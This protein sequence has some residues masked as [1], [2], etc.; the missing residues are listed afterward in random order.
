MRLPEL[1][2]CRGQSGR[3]TFGLTLI[4][5]CLV[6]H[7]LF[8][9]AS[10][11][12]A[13]SRYRS[14]FNYL[15]SLWAF[16]GPRLVSREE[17]R[18]LSILLL[19]AIPCLWIAVCATVKR[20]RDL[21][22]VW[23]YA[24]LLLVPAVNL[25]FF[26]LLCL[27]PGFDKR[28]EAEERGERLRASILPSTKWG[29]AIAGVLGG[30]TVGTA[31]CWFSVGVLGG[32]GTVLFLALPFFMGFLS[33]WLYGYSEPRSSGECFAVATGSV[34]LAGAL[35]VGIAFEGII[36]V[37]MAAPLAV[38][39][40]LLGAGLAHEALKSRHV[41]IQPRALCG[42]FLAIPLL[43]GAELWRPAPLPT[44]T[45]HSSVEVAAA[46]ALVWQRVVAF[47]RIEEKPHWIFRLGM[48]YPLEARMSGAGLGSDRES[49]FSTGISR[50]PV[51]AW[52]ENRYFAFRVAA[53]PPL[54]REL[55]PYGQIR[56]RHLEDRDFR[57]GRVDFR[58]TE[59]P[60]GHTQLDCW[61]SYEN[62]MWPGAYWRLWTDEVVR[63]VQLRVFRHI[64]RL[65]EE[66]GSLG[67]VQ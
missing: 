62:R 20:L 52:E 59:R 46:P 17:R 34:F 39:L 64:K 32:Y 10:A 6:M 7:N 53:E 19:L 26:L 4:F 60:N 5:V 2:D 3:S 51:L 27:V 38:P 43:A 40:A 54:M 56:V 55:S 48:A 58:L 28:E 50:E 23:S 61:P 31:L 24:A 14:G 36:C 15:F 47:P 18:L 49:I 65:A 45:V 13:V 35:I 22:L 57:P 21:G 8:R 29:S 33:A 12:T 66:D 16:F 42:L 41:R 67:A 9:L 11:G 63:Q 1:F 30:T 37:A 25:L 44:Y